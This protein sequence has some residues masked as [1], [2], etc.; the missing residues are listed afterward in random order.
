MSGKVNA[1]DRVD[2]VQQYQEGL[3]SL[4]ESELPV[5][6]YADQLLALLETKEQGQ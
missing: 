4:A 3:E 2:P 5:S 1:P 6:N